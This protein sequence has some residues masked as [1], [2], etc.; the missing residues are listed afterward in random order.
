[1]VKSDTDSPASQMSL[2]GGPGNRAEGARCPLI[3]DGD[4]L[5]PSDMEMSDDGRAPGTVAAFYAE[6]VDGS[7]VEAVAVNLSNAIVGAGIVRFP[8]M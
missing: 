8:M 1:M 3:S 7:S 2:P 4:Q 5:R 6:V